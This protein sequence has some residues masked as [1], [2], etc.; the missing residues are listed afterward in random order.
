MCLLYKENRIKRTERYNIGNYK[1]INLLGK[2]NIKLEMIENTSEKKN[3][4]IKQ[5]SNLKCRKITL[6]NKQNYQG[7]VRQYKNT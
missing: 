5:S 7:L 4:S 2:P 1:N 6:G 3:R